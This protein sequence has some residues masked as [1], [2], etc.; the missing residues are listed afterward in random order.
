MARRRMLGYAVLGALAG[1]AIA[2]AYFRRHLT[3]WARHALPY[4]RQDVS[5]DKP[6]LIINRWS[7]DGK[8]ERFG[9]AEA[10]EAA[11]IEVV[12][13]ERGDDLTQLA[14]DAVAAGADTI[15][16][17]G[18]DGSLGLVAAVASEANIPFFCVPVGTRNHF[19][20]DLGLDREDPLAALDAVRSGEAVLIDYATVA[21]R[22][23]L[24]NVSFGVYAKA[25]HEESYRSQKAD[26]LARV[27]A[28]TA[29]GEGE[30]DPLLFQAPD[31]TKHDSPPLLL[32]SN[33]PYHFSGPPDFGRRPRLDSGKL[34]IG[35]LTRL[36]DSGE[37]ILTLAPPRP[38]AI[39]EWQAESI[40]LDSD[41]EVLAAVDGEALEFESPIDISLQRRGL[42]VLV[43]KGTKPG[44]VSHGEAIAAQLLD[45]ASLSG[46]SG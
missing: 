18:G 4:Q 35:A 11:G 36:P 43:P 7:G 13:L 27:V 30:T 34:G 26:T 19:A 24:N 3:A 5:V 32:I 9:L 22:V 20:L 25:V 2:A 37:T 33:N 41:G 31:G 15:G 16:M 42:S 6:V 44:F 38:G 39:Q 28:E 45:L 46:H 29:A 10:A 14:R 40:T 23:F 21:G 8:A 12:M 17:A 1:G